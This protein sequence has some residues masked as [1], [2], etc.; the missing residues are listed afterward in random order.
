MF[1]LNEREGGHASI[2]KTCWTCQYHQA[3]GQNLLGNC[4]YFEILGEAKKE[5][6]PTVVDKGCRKYVV[7][8]KLVTKIVEVVDGTYC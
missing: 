1:T 3:G 8:N 5:V 7:K 2:T 4:K 6:P